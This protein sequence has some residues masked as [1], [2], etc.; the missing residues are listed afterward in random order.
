M[1]VKK[2][3]EN[4]TVEVMDPWQEKVPI[5][6]PLAARGEENFITASVNGRVFKIRKGETVE[7]PKPIAE[8]LQQAEDA[9]IYAERFIDS[10]VYE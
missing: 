4:V 8:V 5:R 10:K 6:I 3:E 9:D 2:T 1:A 7:V